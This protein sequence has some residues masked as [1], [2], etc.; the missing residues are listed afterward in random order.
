[1]PVFLLISHRKVGSSI[2][3][4]D[5]VCFILTV[6]RGRKLDGKARHSA[7]QAAFS[8]L[9]RVHGICISRFVFLI[10]LILLPIFLI[11]PTQRLPTFS[12]LFFHY[13]SCSMSLPLYLHYFLSIYAFLSFISLPLSLHH[14]LSLCQHLFLTFSFSLLFSS[15]LCVSGL[16]TELVHEELA[17]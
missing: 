14:A 11:S 3:L 15:P 17:S 13:L 12:L 5:F 10:A 7:K 8:A 9:M 6:M 16:L 2:L 1:M 4:K